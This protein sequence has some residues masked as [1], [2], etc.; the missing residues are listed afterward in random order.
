[1]HHRLTTALLVAVLA[2][3]V[4][5]DAN[6][7]AAAFAAYR[8]G[9][10]S[11]ALRVAKPLAEKGDASAQYLLAL[12][13]SLGRGVPFDRCESAM[14]TDRSARQGYTP[15]YHAMAWVYFNAEGV[16]K[17]NVLAYRWGLAA[18][19][20]GDKDAKADIDMFGA[21]LF[22]SQRQQIRATMDRWRPQ[23]QPPLKIRRLPDNAYGWLMERLTGIA[24]C[25]VEFF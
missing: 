12:M 3:A 21:G 25:T 4:P 2:L 16:P 23:D 17:N 19:R 11:E 9:D 7:A 22:E 14:W 15:S 1:M 18:A 13:Y 8:Q 24:R 5:A 6:E 20:T 10:Y